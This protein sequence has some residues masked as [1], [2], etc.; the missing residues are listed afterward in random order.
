M[1]LLLLAFLA[2]DGFVAVLDSLTLIRLG[3]AVGADLGGNLAAP[4]PVGAANRD[5]GRPLAGDMNVLRDRIGDVVAVA[6]L[7]VERAALHRGA[8]ADAVVLE[9]AG[10]A[11]GDARHHV[12]DQRPRGAP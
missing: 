7:Q 9:R 3:R 12:V 2:A 10:K 11:G 1:A 8:I 4:L 5:Q 6:E